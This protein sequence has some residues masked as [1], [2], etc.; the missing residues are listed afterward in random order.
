RLWRRGCGR[1]GAAVGRRGH[2]RY[3]GQRGA[4]G[5]G[6]GPPGCAWKSVGTI[7]AA[8]AAAWR[9]REGSE[10]EAERDA[11]WP[12]QGTSVMQIVDAILLWP[13]ARPAHPAII[14]PHGVQTY[15]MLADAIMAAAGHFAHSEL[16]PAK[17]VAVSI[18]DPARMLIAS[19]GL[20]H[21]G[22]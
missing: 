2:Q 21:A 20:L 16:D 11:A 22:F 18:D 3:G 10:V 1:R 13:N 4:Q 6:S 12:A 7:R 8:G 19:L 17:P 5:Q 15:R 14:Q 9:S